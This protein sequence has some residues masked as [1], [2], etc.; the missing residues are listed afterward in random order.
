MDITSDLRV[1]G[2]L[3]FMEL[4]ISCGF[5]CR[6]GAGGPTPLFGGKKRRNDERK[7]SPQGKLTN[8]QDQPLSM[9]LIY[10]TQNCVFPPKKIIGGFFEGCM[11]VFF[12]FQ[13]VEESMAI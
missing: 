6:G 10:G 4:F 5:T 2:K 1:M 12:L 3:F 13:R 8:P 11:S 9:T 7:K